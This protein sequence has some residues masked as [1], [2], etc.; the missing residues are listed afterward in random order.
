M[1]SCGVLDVVRPYG[2]FVVAGAGFEAAVQDAHKP[3][4]ELAQRGV[5]VGAAGF[6]LV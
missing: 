2:R 4:G 5:M 3:V 6:E 1:S